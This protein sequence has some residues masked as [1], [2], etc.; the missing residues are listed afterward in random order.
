MRAC[1]ADELCRKV[2]L[3][4]KSG[5]KDHQ[6]VPL[7]G[8]ALNPVGCVFGSIQNFYDRNFIEHLQKL[9]PEKGMATTLLSTSRSLTTRFVTP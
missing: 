6:G 2:L 4:M 9:L 8:Q 1:D 5:P 7:D 3:H